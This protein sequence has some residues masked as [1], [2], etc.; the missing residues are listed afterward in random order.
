MWV[1]D[2]FVESAT[3]SQKLLNP[4]S[5]I[6]YRGAVLGIS[7]INIYSH[8]TSD[9][10]KFPFDTQNCSFSISSQGY[11]G[12]YVNLLLFDPWYGVSK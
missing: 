5:I 9:L 11:L 3:G 12:K 4:Y 2:I 7:S 8:C 1:P 6:S 10:T